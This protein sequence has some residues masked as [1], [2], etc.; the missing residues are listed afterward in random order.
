MKPVR[1]MSEWLAW[2]MVGVLLVLALRADAGIQVYERDLVAEKIV[3]DN[4]IHD[5]LWVNP[6][7]AVLLLPFYLIDVLFAIPICKAEARGA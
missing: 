2:F 3:Y 4:C 6:V 5:L 7:A 1:S